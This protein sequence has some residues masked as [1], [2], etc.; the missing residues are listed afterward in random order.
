MGKAAKKAKPKVPTRPF[1]SH[2]GKRVDIPL[3]TGPVAGD[4]FAY[5]GRGYV[6]LTWWANYASTGATIGRGLDLLFDPESVKIPDIAYKIMSTCMRTG[7][8][9]AN[10]RRFATYFYGKTKYYTSARA[11]VNGT[12]HNT[13]IAALAELFE[14][15]L[16]EAKQ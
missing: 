15:M 13:E 14:E 10:G 4:E 16:M 7:Q 6:Q 9:F 12:D 3:L 8:G 11:M 1:V 2:G 5:Y